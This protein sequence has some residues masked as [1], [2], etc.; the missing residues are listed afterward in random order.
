MK[1]KELI[2]TGILRDMSEGVILISPDGIISLVNPAAEHILDRRA[3]EM[4][5][6]SFARCF[7]EYPE[8]DE[9]NQTILDAVYDPAARHVNLV[10]YYTGTVLRQ[11]HVTTSLLRSD[12]E[13]TGI[14]AVLG[15]ISELVELRD[16]VAAME[17]IKAL[18][19]QLELRNRLLHTT[20]GR[21]L[22]D[23]LVNQLLDTPDGLAIGGKKAQITVLMSDLRGFTALSGRIDPQ[24]L[25]TVLNHYLG[26]MTEIIERYGGTIIEFVGD[27]ILSIFGTPIVRSDHAA[28][29]VAAA[30]EMQGRMEAVNCW[31][32]EQGYPELEMGIGINSGEAIVGNVGSERRTRYNVIGSPV[33]LCGRVESCSVGGQVLISRQTR[34]MIETELEIAQELTVA[35][36]GLEEPMTLYQVLSIGAPYGVAF[37]PV[38]EEPEPLAIPVMTRLWRLQEKQSGQTAVPCILTALCPAGAVLETPMDMQPFDNIKLDAGGELFCKVLA[39]RGA[40][41]QVRFTAKPL[42]FSDWQA[43][44]WQQSRVRSEQGLRH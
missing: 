21:Y 12:E 15:D 29:A 5:N 44:V 26:E 7:F 33:N 11:L 32:R 30:I 14:I 43:L 16:A 4:L 22:S 40:G 34:E 35:P 13:N 10:P 3:E 6:K 38:E 36:K 41:W 17:R 1:K 25:I 9:F 24:V 37:R 42:G 8:N 2:Q 23:D 20:F 31:N 28:S 18:N 19:S 27:G 39:K